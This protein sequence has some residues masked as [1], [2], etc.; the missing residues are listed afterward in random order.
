[1]SIDFKRIQKI[2]RS[3]SKVQSTPEEKYWKKFKYPVLSQQ[4]GAVTHIDFAQTK[5]YNFS[6]TCPSR[7]QIFSCASSSEQFS[8]SKFQ[9]PV[10]VSKFRKDGNLLAVAEDSG[11]TKIFDVLHNKKHPV[12]SLKK[13][14]RAV[15]SCYF[16]NNNTTILTC[17]DDKTAKIWDIPTETEIETFLGHQDYVRSGIQNSDQESLWAT[18]SYDHKIKLWD[19]R[20]S[21]KDGKNILTLDHGSPVESIISLRSGGLLVSAGSNEIK[22]WDVISGGKLVQTL[23]NHQKTVSVLTTCR[24]GSRLLSAGLDQLVKVYDVTSFSIL[25]TMKFPAPILSLDVSPNDT[26]IAVGMSNGQLAIRHRKEKEES[27]REKETVKTKFDKDFQFFLSRENINRD[28]MNDV[29]F[30]VGQKRATKLKK[31]DE[32]LKKFQYSKSLDTVLKNDNV[33]LTIGLLE[34]LHSRNSLRR[35]LAGR[36]DKELKPILEFLI[37]NITNSGYSKLLIQVAS[38]LIGIYSKVLGQSPMIDD[39]FI[40]LNQK[41]K[42]ELETQKELA[43]ILGGLDLLF[44]TSLK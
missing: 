10:Y 24:N 17:S 44:Q 41:M 11:V 31:Y 42:V 21:E 1:M 20:I 15:R 4:F 43:K 9:G 6:I 35:A 30:L 29:N 28:L 37:T 25:H 14:K 36:N 8:F 7:V 40:T 33:E 16:S 19:Q 23:D 3:V 22:I 38:I 34:E 13:H 12:R 5:P 27:E 39:L 2:K 32:L 18:G 26:H